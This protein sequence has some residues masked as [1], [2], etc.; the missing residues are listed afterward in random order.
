MRMRRSASDLLVRGLAEHQAMTKQLYSTGGHSRGQ[1]V[2]VGHAALLELSAQGCSRPSTSRAPVSWV[3]A[4]AVAHSRLQ[5]EVP[6]QPVSGADAL[7][8][9]RTAPG[10]D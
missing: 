6:C 5:A 9:T 1:G 10:R 4:R 8:S 2:G 3:E 7:P